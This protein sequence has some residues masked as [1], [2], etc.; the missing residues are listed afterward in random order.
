[1]ISKKNSKNDGFTLIELLVAM[2][3]IGIL[4]TISIGSFQSSQMKSR[5]TRRKN[6]LEQIS[7]ALEAYVNDK[8]EYPDN[9]VDFKIAGCANESSC[10]WG[11]EWSDENDTIYMIEMPADQTTTLT[12]YYLSDGS[13]FQLY[14]RLENDQ[15]RSIPTLTDSPA[16][17]GLSCGDLRCNYGVSSSNKTVEDGRIPVLD[18]P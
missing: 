18:S 12:Y 7:N 17:Y 3:V 2:A 4:V 14:A 13:Y 1:M 10:E 9:S 8:G 11:E 6:D 16:N 5:D 15:D